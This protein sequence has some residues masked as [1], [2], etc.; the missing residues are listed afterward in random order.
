MY[1]S[2]TLLWALNYLVSL[3]PHYHNI[4]NV[5][6]IKTVSRSVNVTVHFFRKSDDWWC[7]LFYQLISLCTFAQNSLL[8]VTLAAWS[9]KVM[10]QAEAEE[11]QGKDRT[12]WVTD[13]M[14]FPKPFVPPDRFLREGTV[15]QTK[16]Q[17]PEWLMF[18]CVALEPG[19]DAPKGLVLNVADPVWGISVLSD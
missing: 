4:P 6:G 5:V 7:V 2:S 11:A 17:V 13:A 12:C 10:A 18:L 3:L 8:L 1:G 15:K 19:P 16:Q 9:V 14:D